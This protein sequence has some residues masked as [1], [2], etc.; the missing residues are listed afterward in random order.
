MV[1]IRVDPD[2]DP[3]HALP[4][5][6]RSG[7]QLIHD[8]DHLP[9]LKTQKQTGRKFGPAYLS[10]TVGEMIRSQIRKKNIPSDLN[11]LAM[12]FLVVKLSAIF[13]NS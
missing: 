6:L 13:T 5:H 11:F 8:K 9:I 1:Q 7:T 2:L 3:H 10:N 4:N 12:Q